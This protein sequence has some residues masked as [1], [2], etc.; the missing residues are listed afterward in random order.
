MRARLTAF[1]FILRPHNMLASAL[2]VL[3]GNYIAHGGRDGLAAVAVLTALV[4]GAGNILNDYFDLDVDRINKPGRPL[5]AGRISPRGALVMYALLSVAVTAGAVFFAPWHAAWLIIGWQIA[6]AVYARWCKRW[7]VAGNVLVA[8]ISSSAFLAGALVAGNATAAWVPGAIAFAFVLCREIVKG[9]EDVEGDSAG[10]VH[11]LASVFGQARAGTTAAVC[12]LVLAALL[13][14]P[15]LALG[16][17][18]GYLIAMEL[19]VAPVLLGGAVRVTG[20]T[21]RRDYTLT[22]RALKLGMFLGIAAIALGA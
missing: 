12:M 6:L 5:P 20:S 13:P 22:S 11:T 7:L 15:A 4:T 19:L 18:A 17:H 8:A 3:A 2:A 1:I 16:Y 10:G 14:V 21:H 9:A